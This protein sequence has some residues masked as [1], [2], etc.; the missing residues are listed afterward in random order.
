[1]KKI[2]TFLMMFLMTGGILMAQSF[3][4][5]AVLR[6]SQN[7]LVTNQSGTVTFKVIEGENEDGVTW[8]A[9]N[10]TTND[11]GLVSLLLPNKSDVNWS[12]AEIVATFNFTDQQIPA[13]TVTTPVTAVPYALQAGDV[14]LTTDAI[15]KYINNGDEDHVTNGDD[16]AEMYTALK[17][18]PAHNTLRDS[19]VEYI[20]SN[21]EL[22]KQILLSYFDQISADDLREAY[23]S[24]LNVSENVKTAF[25]DA[26]KDYL[27]NHRMLVVD[28]A[29]HF[30]RTAT[31]SE[32][33]K[34]YNDLKG[35]AAA[36]ETERILRRYFEDYLRSKEYICN[37][38]TLCDIIALLNATS[39]CN[40]SSDKFSYNV[41]RITYNDKPAVQLSFNKNTPYIVPST[42]DFVVS[43]AIPTQSQSVTTSEY[44]VVTTS[45]YIVSN[46]DYIVI[47]ENQNPQELA[48][49]YDLKVGV[50]GCSGKIKLATQKTVPVN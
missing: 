39:D 40:V 4:Y 41:S 9:I 16:W 17:N 49:Q 44:I 10:F 32:V 38:T 2:I 11:N 18:N 36:L 43:Y 48:V 14:K 33:T 50:A 42:V 30:V 26:V 7:Q 20:K 6:D 21:K 23:D 22:A 3:R 47:L 1:M 8:D 29:E 35:S 28:V 24:A 27:K 46:G 25:Y 34:L 5:Q 13:I 37:G 12:N 15:V 19:I 45:E 31:D